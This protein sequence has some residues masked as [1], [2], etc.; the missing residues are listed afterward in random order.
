MWPGSLTPIPR[1]SDC[2]GF[3]DHKQE[4]PRRAAGTIKIQ[5]KVANTRAGNLS[6]LLVLESFTTDPVVVSSKDDYSLETL[7]SQ[8]KP[9]SDRS[10]YQSLSSPEGGA[11][12]VICRLLA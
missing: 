6:H 5:G 2:P 3:D 10:A 8:H 7:P 4:L 11:I 12:A 9:L 1:D